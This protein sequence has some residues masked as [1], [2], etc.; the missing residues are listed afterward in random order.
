MTPRVISQKFPIG[1]AM[2]AF[3]TR[4]A[5]ALLATSALAACTTYP[6]DGQGAMRPNYPTRLPPGGDRKSVV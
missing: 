5:L 6:A 4:T 3:F 1:P 2:T